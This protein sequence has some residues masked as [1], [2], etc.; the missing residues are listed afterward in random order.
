MAGGEVEH[1]LRNWIEQA[2]SPIGVLTNDAD[3]AQWVALNFLAW[4]QSQVKVH[5]TAVDG[6]VARLTELA[7]ELGISHETETGDEAFHVLE[8]IQD[9]LG[10]LKSM[11][12]LSP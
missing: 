11:F 1:V 5:L 4:W 8:S 6:G 12:G 2:N 9:E 3:R 10:A 7:K